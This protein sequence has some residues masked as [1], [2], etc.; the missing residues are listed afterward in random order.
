MPRGDRTGPWGEG[1]MT[2]RGLGFCSGYDRPGFMNPAPGFG[3][4]RGFG[5]GRGFGRAR[6]FGRGWG[7][8]F[9][10][11]Y[12]YPVPTQS[13]SVAQFQPQLTKEQEIQFLEQEVKALEDELALIRKR[14]EELRK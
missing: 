5:R 3:F 13:M 6:G 7:R 12:P 8:G 2:G 1:P 9:G 14:L 4:R 10:W 11:N